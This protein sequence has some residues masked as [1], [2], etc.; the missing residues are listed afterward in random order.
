MTLQSD[1]FKYMES[2]EYLSLKV[3]SQ[4]ATQDSSVTFCK[5]EPQDSQKSKSLPVN[6][7]STKRKVLGGK[8]PPHIDH[9][10]ETLHIK[11]VSHVIELALPLF[12][13]E[14]CLLYT[15]D[16]ADEERLV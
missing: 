12:S 16:A 4:M 15:S 8:S 2:E 13:G 10:S 11:L 3:P 1:D 9:C 5:N 14:A 6:G 7:E